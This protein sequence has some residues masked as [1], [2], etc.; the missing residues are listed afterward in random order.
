MHHIMAK[1]W[2]ILAARGA[3]G[4]LLGV[5]ALFMVVD[6]QQPTLNLFGL[7]LFIRPA[8]IVAHLVTL[9]G[10]YA[11]LD[12]LFAVVLGS[13]NYGEGR[14]WPSLILEGSVSILLGAVTWLWP[15]LSIMALLAWIAG[16]A[17]A[18]G[19]L[20][21]AQGLDVNEYKDRRALF[22][23]TGAVSVVY[24]LLVAFAELRGVDLL[25]LTG[26][27]AFLSGIPLLVMAFHLK[28]YVRRK[29]HAGDP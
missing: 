3:L 2:W 26:A 15:G 24:G 20:E 13:Q 19:I 21:M 7:N 27:Y 12:G 6:V 25:W 9:L 4:V 1:F 23:M 16:W 8:V 18:T 14:R 5:L 29:R 11:F 28:H 10:L 17:V 22:F